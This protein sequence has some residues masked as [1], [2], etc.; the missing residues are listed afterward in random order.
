MNSVTLANLRAGVRRKSDSQNQVDRHPNTEIDAY[1]NHANR[2]LY[3]RLA[4]LSLLKC[5]KTFTLTA[6]GSVT[7]ALPE[8]FYLAYTISEQQNSNQYRHLERHNGT[9]RPFGL[10]NVSGDAVSYDLAD[11]VAQGDR[12]RIQFYP[13]PSSGTYIVQYIPECPLLVQDQDTVAYPLNWYEAIEYDAA[14]QVLEKDDLPRAE[15]AARLQEINAEIN[16]AAASRDL[17]QT[18]HIRDVRNS[19]GRDPADQFDYEL[20]WMRGR[21]WKLY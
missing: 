5:V 4:G 20:P 18:Y 17:A 8:D 2:R 10:P 11:P 14:I 16:A 6:D 12:S 1:I 13:Q 3:T 21:N 15:L 7:Y 19:Y 9:D